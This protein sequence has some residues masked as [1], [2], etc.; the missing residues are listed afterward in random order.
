M[1][2]RPV[3]ARVNE[4]EPLTIFASNPP[5]QTEVQALINQLNDLLDTM[6]R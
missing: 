1:P 3:A 5:T 6:K 4:F 2:L